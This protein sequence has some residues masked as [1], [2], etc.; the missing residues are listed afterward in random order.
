[1]QDFLKLQKNKKNIY[2]WGS[3]SKVA[4]KGARG[5]LRGFQILTDFGFLTNFKC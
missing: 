4:D 5:H 1:L 2:T 3:L